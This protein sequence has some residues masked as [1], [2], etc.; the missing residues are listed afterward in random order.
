MPY[1]YILY[2]QKTD[3]YYVGSTD[4]LTR[5]FS[6]HNR[7]QTQSTRAGVPWMMKFCMETNNAGSF[8]RKLKRQ[9][10]RVL[11]ERIIMEQRLQGGSFYEN[12]KNI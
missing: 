2:S 1:L 3:K 9:K 4:D 10:S 12:L 11:L 7:G 5:R 6:E 8:E